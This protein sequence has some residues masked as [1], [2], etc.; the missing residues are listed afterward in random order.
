MP[1]A[2]VVTGLRAEL[3]GFTVFG[4]GIGVNVVNYTAGLTTPGNT[5][6][7]NNDCDST[8]AG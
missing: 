2:D 3:E 6:D 4:R 5:P 8:G 7:L 1:R